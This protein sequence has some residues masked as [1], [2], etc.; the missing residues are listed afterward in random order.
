MGARIEAREEGE[1]AEVPDDAEALAEHEA[2]DED[3]VQLEVLERA[4]PAPLDDAETTR[5]DA[6]E[7]REAR[8][9]CLLYTSPSPRD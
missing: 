5:R 8:D 3:G 1:E 2:S 4:G 9:A 7:A 6:D